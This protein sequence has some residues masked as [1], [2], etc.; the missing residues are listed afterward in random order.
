MREPEVA[1]TISVGRVEHDVV[2]QHVCGQVPQEVHVHDVAIA[3]LKT[4]RSVLVF[5]LK[6]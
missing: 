3:R 6:Q 2:A 4:V 1:V 5:K